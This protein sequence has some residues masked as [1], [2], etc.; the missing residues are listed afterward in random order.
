[1]QLAKP[2]LA[3]PHNGRGQAGLQTKAWQGSQTAKPGFHPEGQVERPGK[4]TFS[5]FQGFILRVHFCA[6]NTPV[7]H[8]PLF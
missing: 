3:W 8:K 5:G 1:M 4:S 6:M 7:C 2:G